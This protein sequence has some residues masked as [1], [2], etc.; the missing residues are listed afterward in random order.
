V[1]VLEKYPLLLTETLGLSSEYALIGHINDLYDNIL[2]ADF[3]NNK[4]RN[5]IFLFVSVRSYEI[6]YSKA[7][8]SEGAEHLLRQLAALAL[9]V[10][11]ILLPPVLFIE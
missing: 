1:Q 2:A 7:G 3:Q 6:F 11:N 5:D 8:S 9:V 4:V 10:N